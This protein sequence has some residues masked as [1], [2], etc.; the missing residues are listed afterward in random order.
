MITALVGIWWFWVALALVLGLVE[1]LAPSFIFLGFALGAL[2]TS[3]YV[4][5]ADVPSLAVLLAV[6]A[7]FSLVA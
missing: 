1:L 4:G 5:F 6:F 7:A 2:A 3:A